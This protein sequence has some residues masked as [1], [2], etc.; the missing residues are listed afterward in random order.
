MTAERQEKTGVRLLLVGSDPALR[1]EAR[2]AAAT[3]GARLDVALDL[4]A[5]FARLLDPAELCTH[6]LVPAWLDPLKVDALE[7]MVDEV[8]RRPVPILRI[9]AG[10][11]AW[12]PGDAATVAEAMAVLAAPPPEPSAD[13]PPG[14]LTA[15][16][17]RR[18][19]HTGR[20]RMRFQPV[21][22]ATTLTPVGVEVLARLHHAA[23]GILRPNE[24]LPLATASGQERA[25]AAIAAARA[26]LELRAAGPTDAGIL[27]L[28][29]PLTTFCHDIAVEWALEMSAVADIPPARVSIEL[30]ETPHEPDWARLSVAVERWRAAGFYVT[31]DDA[32]PPL[33][34]WRR[35]LDLPFSGV[36]LD[37]SIAGPSAAAM[38]EADAIVEAAL[39][40]GLFVVAEGIED[41]A[42]LRR[43]RARGAQALQGYLFSRPLP[44]AALPVWLGEW[45]RKKNVLF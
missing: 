38:A 11:A 30:L 13:R 39:A 18:A 8:T 20:L 26:M 34:H 36:K 9:G 37:A 45:E 3:A 1:D 40:R 2:Q 15:A 24:F 43:A 22:E 12:A 44:A 33:P 6:L 42:A 32:G 7:G 17:L 23:L 28:N 27:A 16:A 25:F 29:V 35:M 14:K 41:L 4:D 31:I 21:L 5:A 19:L 10:G